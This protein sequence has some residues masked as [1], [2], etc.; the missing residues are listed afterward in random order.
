MLGILLPRYNRSVTEKKVAAAKKLEEMQ[1]SQMMN[2]AL[3]VENTPN[4]FKD[5]I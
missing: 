2:P 4:I 3:K 1:R 5:L